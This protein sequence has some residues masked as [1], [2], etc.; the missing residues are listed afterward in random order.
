MRLICFIAAL[1][2]SSIAF[3]QSFPTRTVTIVVPYPPGGLI[4]IVARI[5]QPR[6]QQELGQT[7]VVDNR[8]GAGGN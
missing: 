7:V 8:S 6:F 5:L 4:D 2:A 3:A 1:A